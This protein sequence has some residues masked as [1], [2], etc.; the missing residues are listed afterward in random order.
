MKSTKYSI[1]ILILITIFC[2]SFT[3]TELHSSKNCD[4]TNFYKAVSPNDRDTKVLT[5][6]GEIEDIDVILVPTRLDNDIYKVKL[7]RKGSNLYKIEQ[8][9]LYVETNY[10]YEYSTYEDVILKVTSSYGYTKG[11]LIFD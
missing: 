9:D 7:T 1:L 11:T 3:S 2:T 6:R 4:V 10:C 8:T 5:R